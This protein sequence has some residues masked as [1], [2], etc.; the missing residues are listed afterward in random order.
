MTRAGLVAMGLAVALPLSP[1]RAAQVQTPTFRSSTD[2]VPVYVSVRS[3][4]SFVQGLEVKDFELSDNGVTQEVDNVSSDA[5]PID[6]TLV[7][8]TSS[9]VINSLTAFRADV[10]RIT[11][12]LRPEEQMRLITFDSDV[13]EI[14]PMQPPP[15]KPPV[16]EIRLG[17][18]TS[19]NDG[20][21]FALARDRRADR[22]HLVFVFTDGYD[23]FSVLDYGALPEI[24]S[25]AD[26]L[27]HVVLVRPNVVPDAR[28]SRDF[29]LITEAAVRTGG[30][31]YQSSGRN[32]IVAS[33]QEA[34]EAFRRSYVVVFAPKDKKEGWHALT[35]KVVKS[36][37]YDV[38]ARQGYY[39]R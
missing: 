5:V 4:G 35:V 24:A 34:I 16:S 21:L 36:G 39:P 9:S 20:L 17:D 12:L 1:G 18:A 29:A 19:L 27:L 6:V 31:I 3:G 32:D 7:V 22:R 25:R 13:R 2:I 30:A 38:R 33:F 15:K 10:G 37:D 8:D 28:S 11:E 14:L 26:A 23:T